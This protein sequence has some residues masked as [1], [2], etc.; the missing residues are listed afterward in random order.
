MANPTISQITIGSN[1]YDICDATVRDSVSSLV[2]ENTEVETSIDNLSMNIGAANPVPGG[3]WPKNLRIG[4]KYDV[5]QKDLGTNT[6]INSRMETDGRARAAFGFCRHSDSDNTTVLNA[7]YMGVK[8]DKSRYVSMTD[9]KAWRV[10]LGATDNNGR[11]SQNLI[12]SNIVSNFGNTTSVTAGAIKHSGNWT[13]LTSLSVPAGAW[14]L[15]YGAAISPFPDTFFSNYLDTLKSATTITQVVNR[16]ENVILAASG[17]TIDLYCGTETGGLE[18]ARSISIPYCLT[19]QSNRS[20]QLSS[21]SHVNFTTATT[22]R[23][24]IRINGLGGGTVDCSG[25]VVAYQIG[26]PAD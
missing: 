10:G 3:V 16:I 1:T 14:L 17:A 6:Y 13:T 9:P 23:V 18:R 24:C 19:K 21:V 20:M 25:G 22:V 26:Y 4:T 12:R 11:W 5:Q 8:D 15:V 7:F 2:E